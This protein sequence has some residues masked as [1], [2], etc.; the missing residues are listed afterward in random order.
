MKLNDETR[1]STDVRQHWD[2]DSKWD[3]MSDDVLAR[4]PDGWFTLEKETITL[5]STLAPGEI[6]CQSLESFA[7]IIAEL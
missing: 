3:D 5:P 6:D 4:F 7:M 2:I 1:W